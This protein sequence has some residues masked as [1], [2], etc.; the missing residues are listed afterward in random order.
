LFAQA[1]ATDNAVVRID[2]H[3]DLNLSGMFSLRVA[4]GV[5]ILGDRSAVRAG[6]RLFTT[7]FPPALLQVGIQKEDGT[8]VPSDHVRISGIRLD[9]GESDD[10]FSAVGKEDADGIAV[11]SSQDVEIDHNEIYRWRGAGVNVHDFAGRINRDNANTVA[12]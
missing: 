4:P 10:P 3:L 11:V 9:G 6:P 7:T 2:G 5:Q 1:I 8:V 12:V